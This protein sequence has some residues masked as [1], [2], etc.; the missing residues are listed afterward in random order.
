[1]DAVTGARCARHPQVP[2]VETCGRCGTFVCPECIQLTEQTV[3]CPAC[4]AREEGPSRASASAGRILVYLSLAGLVVLLGWLVSL[5]A[6]RW[7]TP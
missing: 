4:E 3:L 7:R 2:A 1:M 5:W 6:T